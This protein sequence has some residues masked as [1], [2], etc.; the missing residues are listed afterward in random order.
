MDLLQGLA[1]VPLTRNACCPEG[2]L[3]QACLVFFTLSVSGDGAN[4][5]HKRINDHIQVRLDTVL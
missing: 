3:R 2:M 4:S 1:T 5:G